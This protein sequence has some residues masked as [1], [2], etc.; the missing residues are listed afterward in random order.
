MRT[1]PHET[2]PSGARI[3]MRAR[4]RAKS[5]GAD[6]SKVLVVKTKTGV[7][8]VASQT[9]SVGEQFVTVPATMTLSEA[10]AMTSPVLAPVLRQLYA[11]HQLNT[12][13]TVGRLLSGLSR[14]EGV[15][16]VVVSADYTAGVEWQPYSSLV[17]TLVYEACH[18]PS[19]FW[20][21]YFKLLPTSFDGAPP[22]ALPFPASGDTFPRAGHPN[23]LTASEKAI[24][25]RLSQFR[26]KILQ[27]CP[28]CVVLTHRAWRSPHSADS[29]Q[30]GVTAVVR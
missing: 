16:V 27:V 21:P 30:R 18:N 15:R 9:I 22:P 7:G 13:G 19:S 6:L 17:V 1:I 23:Y 10:R 3:P 12:T 20:I 29:D 5:A 4:R 14:W 2:P 26:K 8:L 28:S 25:Y 24:G 11:T